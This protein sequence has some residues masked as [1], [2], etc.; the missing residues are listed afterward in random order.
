LVL[1]ATQLK[2]KIRGLNL[3][4][5]FIEGLP[6]CGLPITH[7]KQEGLDPLF[8]DLVSSAKAWIHWS[9][10]IQTIANSVPDDTKK[11]HGNSTTIF[12]ISLLKQR[13]DHKG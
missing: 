12:A 4:V 5:P 8:P 7:W 6:P 11:R 9:F 2:E 3:R 1:Q 10:P 13:I